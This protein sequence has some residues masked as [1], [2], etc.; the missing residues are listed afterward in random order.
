MAERAPSPSSL[1]NGSKLARE[2]PP[3]A[4]NG[5]GSFLDRK[6]RQAGDWIEA[7]PKGRWLVI[8]GIL[9]VTLPPGIVLVAFPGFSQELQGFSFAGVFLVNFLANFPVVPIPGLSPLGQAVILSQAARS[10]MPWLVGVSGGLGMGLGET[11]VYY[12]G[13]AGQRAARGK[14]LPGPP[15]FRH[16]AIWIGRLIAHLMQRWGMITIFVL[17]AVPN[18][19]FEVAG[20]TAGTTRMGFRR[21]IIPAVFG[22]IVRGMLLVYLASYIPFT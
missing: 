2:L 22:K 6:T 20:L 10:S 4:V 21:Y 8:V 7:H 18:P 3:S 16:A 12:T 11:S 9:V 1:A 14:Q 19:I 15:W 17:S 13:I 5:D